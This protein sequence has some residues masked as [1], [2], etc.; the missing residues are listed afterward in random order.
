EV[1]RLVAAPQ[2][3]VRTWIDGRTNRQRPVIINQLGRMDSTTAISFTNL[4][5]LR[6][7]AVFAGAG[8]KLPAIRAILDEVRDAIDHPHPF[9]TS[10]VFKTDGKKIVA[11]I[12]RSNGV[13]V[14]YDLKSKNYEMP[15]VVLKS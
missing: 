3:L 14:L 1:A 2:A 10:T 4:M 9:A 15:V 11:D 8:V 7:V 13:D 5:E 6:F 12:A